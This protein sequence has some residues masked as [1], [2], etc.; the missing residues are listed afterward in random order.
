[1]TIGAVA[2]SGA[3]SYASL[4]RENGLRKRILSLHFP[5]LPLSLFLSRSAIALFQHPAMKA[6]YE[7]HYGN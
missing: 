7:A 1:M 6:R 4:T 2:I 5:P 3:L